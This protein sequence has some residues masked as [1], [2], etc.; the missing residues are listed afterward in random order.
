MDSTFQ[1]LEPSTLPSQWIVWL[2]LL[3]AK[4]ACNKCPFLQLLTIDKRADLMHIK[5]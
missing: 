4:I 5:I 2:L 3:N 1:P